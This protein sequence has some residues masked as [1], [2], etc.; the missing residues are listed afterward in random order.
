MRGR[1]LLLNTLLLTAT[2]FLMRA[3]SVT[4]QIYLSNKIGAA[5]IGL[6]QLIMSINMLAFTFVARV[7]TLFIRKIVVKIE[8]KAPMARV[9]ELL[10]QVQKEMIMEDRCLLYTSRCV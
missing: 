10:L 9:R 2:A 6:F 7:Q 3:V 4:F 1:N 5:G 8:T